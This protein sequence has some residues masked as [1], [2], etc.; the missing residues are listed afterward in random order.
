[1]QARP[2]A[3]LYSSA[4]RH[5]TALHHTTQH[6]IASNHSAPH[7]TT[8]CCTCLLEASCIVGC[9][10][11]QRRVSRRRHARRHRQPGVHWPTASLATW[12]C[13]L[14]SLRGLW[15]ALSACLRWCRSAVRSSLSLFVAEAISP[16]RKPDPGDDIE[17]NLPLC[18]C[19][20]ARARAR[21]CA[22][23]SCARMHARPRART[24]VRDAR[25]ASHTRTRRSAGGSAPA[26]RQARA[27]GRRTG[28]SAQPMHAVQATVSSAAHARARVAPVCV[29][30]HMRACVCPRTHAHESARE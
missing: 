7:D 26:R 22:H 6:H 15:R 18:A 17:D 16:A 14:L 23:T 8:S 19:I 3:S 5:H 12:F 28:P 20:R 11:R 27:R 24:C 1:M 21:I 10:P 2:L 29:H 13:Y 9:Q 30:A 25:A 4:T